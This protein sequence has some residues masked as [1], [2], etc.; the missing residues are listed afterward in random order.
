MRV[1]VQRVKE[2]SCIVDGIE[3]NS[4]KKGLLLLI[5]FTQS[6]TIAEVQKMAKKIVN[7]RIF[8]DENKK[9]NLSVVNVNGQ[10]LAISQ[11][12]LYADTSS[13][14]RPSF[15]KASPP[16]TANMLYLKFIEILNEIYNVPTFPGMFG[17]DMKLPIVCDG[18]VTINL[19]M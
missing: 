15:V 6:D 12:T 5:G 14:N 8:E 4:I 3:I 10:I 11:F 7:L 13:G 16:D 2:A 18:P 17:A 9:M 1:V 19:E